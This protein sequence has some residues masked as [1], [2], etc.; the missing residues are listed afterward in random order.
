MYMSSPHLCGKVLYNVC[1][2]VYFCGKVCVYV[3]INDDLNVSRSC[4]LSEQSITTAQKCQ[5]R[6][7]KFSRGLTT[8]KYQSFL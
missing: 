8:Q 7:D 5:G 2:K 3:L 6:A 4:D 1:I